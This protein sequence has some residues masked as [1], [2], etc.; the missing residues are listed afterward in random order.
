MRAAGMSCDYD[1]YDR[2]YQWLEVRNLFHT[3]DAHLH[4][5]SIG[6]VSVACKDPI[7]CKNAETIVA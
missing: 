4:S 2:F 7:N 6:V 1:D 3:E 5:F